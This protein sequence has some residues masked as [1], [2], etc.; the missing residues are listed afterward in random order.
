Q[1]ANHAKDEFLAV[2]SHELRTPLN[3]ILG[4]AR[5]LRDGKLDSADIQRGIETIERN[6]KTQVQLIE[7]LLDVSRIVVNKL[8]LSISTVEMV[9]VIAAAVDAVRPMAQLK[10]IQIHSSIDGATGAISG[11]PVRL[12][13]VIWNLLSNAIKFTPRNGRVEVALQ[14][15]QSHIQ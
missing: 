9:P 2:V 3:S 11:D 5:M 4:W 8:R 14:R 12:Q 6:A 7:D 15:T 13:Q 10:G 1:N